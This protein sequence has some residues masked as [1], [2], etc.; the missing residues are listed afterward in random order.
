MAGS[1]SCRQ[2]SST[3]RRPAISS[4]RRLLSGR[5]VNGCDTSWR[6]SSTGLMRLCTACA[7]VA[8][9]ARQTQETFTAVSHPE[10]E[11]CAM[12]RVQIAAGSSARMLS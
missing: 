12:V 7:A 6:R 9:Q 8:R 11:V 4:P 1:S 5:V 10:A 2:L 3:M